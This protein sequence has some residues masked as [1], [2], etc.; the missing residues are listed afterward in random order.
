MTSYVKARTRAF[1]KIAKSLLAS[2]F[3]R[4]DGAIAR[5]AYNLS[6]THRLKFDPQYKV[7][8]LLDPRFPGEWKTRVEDK[9][10]CLPYRPFYVG[11]GKGNREKAHAKEAAGLDNPTQ[12]N[13]RKLRTIRQIHKAGL[14]P[15]EF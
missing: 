7:Y 2:K 12:G 1:K 8:L 11:K 5:L 13:L 3:P 15:I 6:E 9:H 10:L 14:N 4:F